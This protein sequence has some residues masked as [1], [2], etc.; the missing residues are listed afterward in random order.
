MSSPKTLEQLHNAFIEQLK[1]RNRIHLLPFDKQHWFLGSYSTIQRTLRDGF[2]PLSIAEKDACADLLFSEVPRISEVDF[3]SKLKELV[4]RVAQD[5]KVSIGHAQKLI[6]ILMKYA[7]ACCGHAD[8]HLP[9]DW[10]SFAQSESGRM[11]VPIDAIVLYKLSELHP[12]E[13]SDVEAGAGKDKKGRPTYWAKVVT[14]NK[15]QAWSRITDYTTYWSLQTRIRR[16]A[17]AKNVV[18]LEF[19]MRHLWV[20]E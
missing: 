15:S 14:E 11:P 2:S 17:E 6:S 13:F 1:A 9:D 19:E 8:A 5:F 12:Q 16:L 20:A 10:K 18:P 3:D 7:A 4:L